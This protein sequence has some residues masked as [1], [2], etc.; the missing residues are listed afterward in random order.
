MQANFFL[1]RGLAAYTIHYLSGATPVES[2]RAV[3]D[4]SDD[5]GLDAIY[6]DEPNKRLF[7][8]QSKWIHDG[9]GEPENGDIKKFIA[10]VRDLFNLKFDRF[11]PKVRAKQHSITQALNDPVTRYEVVVAYT[12]TSG[13]SMPSQRDLADLSAEM[14]DTS[15]VVYVTVLNQ[16]E[17][18]GSLTAGI[19]GE[20]INLEIG[21]KAWG[22]KE[23]PYEAFYGQLTGNKS[24]HGGQNLE[25]GSSLATFAACSAKPT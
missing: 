8:V 2:A 1:T 14:N 23:N 7:L 15:E 22:R 5:N 21:L 9:N 10:G 20:P 17:L 13:L 24:L 3:T 16:A 25:D 19:A 12:G 18:H 11:N 6:Y 4:G